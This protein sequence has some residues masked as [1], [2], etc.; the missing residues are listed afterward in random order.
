M[1]NPLFI[2]RETPAGASLS[3]QEYALEQG[4]AMCPVC[5]RT[6]MLEGGSIEVDGIHCWSTIV[7]L[8]CETTWDDVYTLNYYDNL[9]LQIDDV[10]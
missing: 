7:C 4:G 10:D 9:E 3:P 1:A 2:D 8:A 6:D 5:E